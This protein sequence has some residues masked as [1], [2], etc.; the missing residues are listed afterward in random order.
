MN[1][2]GAPIAESTLKRAFAT[3]K[4]LAKIERRFRFHDLRHTFA[5]T[6]ASQGVSLQVIR[7]RSATRRRR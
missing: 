3:A 2:E 5:S 1:D 6:L 7:A 4:R